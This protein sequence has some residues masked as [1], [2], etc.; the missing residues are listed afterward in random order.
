MNRKSNF[1]IILLVSMVSALLYPGTTRG[2]HSDAEVHAFQEELN[3]IADGA[4]LSFE[5]YERTLSK[6]LKRQSRFSLQRWLSQFFASTSHGNVGALGI[7]NAILLAIVMLA[8]IAVV[9]FFLWKIRDTLIVGV[10]DVPSQPSEDSPITE[11]EALDQAEAFEIHR[12]FREAL[13]SLYLAALLHLQGCGLLPYDKSLTNREHLRELKAQ[14]NLQN[15]LRPV[16][17]IFDDVWY[18]H[19]LCSAD[20]VTEYRGLLQKVYDACL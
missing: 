3:A 18:G 20:T 15:A 7:L 10:E 9:L 5:Q 8:L 17:H 1:R 14:P 13:R 4:D 6:L 16:I 11:R 12:N 19:R 2:Q